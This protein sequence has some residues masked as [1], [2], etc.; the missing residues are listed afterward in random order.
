MGST[1]SGPISSKHVERHEKWGILVA[2]AEMQGYREAQEDF[3]TIKLGMPGKPD[4][5]FLG[6]YDGHSGAKA[7]KFL[8]ENLWKNVSKLSDPMDQA[9]LRE[10][11]LKT[12]AAFLKSEDTLE[13]KNNGA[14]CIFAVLKQQT[15]KDAWDIVV[16]NIGDSRV[17]I[18]RQ[19]GSLTELS[20]DHKPD[21]LEEKARIEKAGGHV[22][23]NRVDGQL[24][25][26][27]AMGDYQYK[28]NEAIGVEE[29]KVIPVADFMTATIEKGDLL[30]M[31][32]DGIVEAMENSQVCECVHTEWNSADSEKDLVEVLCRLFELSLITGSKDNHTSIL[33]AFGETEEIV[34]AHTT[35]RGKDFYAGPYSCYG[36]SE[37]FQKAYKEDAA[38]AGIK[39]E[40]QILEGEQSAQTKKMEVFQVMQNQS[41]QAM[42]MMGQHIMQDPNL[43]ESQ[44]MEAL[45]QLLTGMSSNEE[46][47][48]QKNAR[49]MR[50]KI[51]ELTKAAPGTAPAPAKI[52]KSK[53][54]AC[55]KAPEALKK[56]GGCAFA[57]YCS[58]DC[59]KSAW[60]T[61]K[62]QC[63][64]SAEVVPAATAT[65]ANTESKKKGKK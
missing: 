8:S 1:L 32:C 30:L 45:K 46:L 49:I 17:I 12:D 34:A 60:K 40:K 2:A 47:E 54:N 56:C 48:E 20:N 25:M 44:R 5:I 11:A 65:T 38:K 61:H 19:D 27:R 29:Q 9:L 6:V 55:G 53:C 23:N 26:S 3:H 13:G 51:Q 39:T 50:E 58:P 15:G 10:C 21:N 24:A 7:S 52:D 14:A 42:Q 62:V 43:S 37:E 31:C 4:H 22:A 36:S 64:K 28:N 41:S 16:G 59:Q 18:V 33:L 57:F 63:K 35:R